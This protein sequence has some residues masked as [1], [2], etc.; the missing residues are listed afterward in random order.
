MDCPRASGA[1]SRNTRPEIIMSPI[2]WPQ[3]HGYE[4]RLS[5]RQIHV[6]PVTHVDVAIS[7]SGYS[8]FE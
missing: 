4:F 1:T 3:K 8:M 7:I 2:G 6:G 5:Q